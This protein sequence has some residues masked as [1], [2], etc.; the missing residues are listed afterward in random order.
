MT[1]F[2][3][4]EIRTYLG[5]VGD[6]DE[7]DEVMVEAMADIMV[8]LD[9]SIRALPDYASITIFTLA[10]LAFT[11]GQ[12][13]TTTRLAAWTAGADLAFEPV[14]HLQ[15]GGEARVYWLL[16]EP[17]TTHRGEVLS[18]VEQPTTRFTTGIFVRGAW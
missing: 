5:E 4:D 14:R 1:P 7:P 18:V 15:V 6:I 12:N 17:T 10:A 2:T 11:Y 9:L 3:K 13:A 16:G 8:A